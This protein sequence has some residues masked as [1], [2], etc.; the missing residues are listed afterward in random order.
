[1][2]AKNSKKFFGEVFYLYTQKGFSMPIQSTSMLQSYIIPQSNSSTTQNKKTLEETAN[3]K[4]Y[5][6]TLMFDLLRNQYKVTDRNLN[7][8]IPFD[9]KDKL[10]SQDKFDILLHVYKKKYKSNALN[11]IITKYFVLFTNKH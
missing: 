8:A 5:V 7:Y 6:K 4:K 3:D 1:M 11:Q 2:S 10:T 9:N